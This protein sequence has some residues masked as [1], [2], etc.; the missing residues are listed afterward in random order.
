[1]ETLEKIAYHGLIHPPYP[2]INTFVKPAS[3]GTKL[4]KLFYALIGAGIVFGI[5]FAIGSANDIAWLRYTGMGLGGIIFIFAAI[6]AFKAQEAPCPYCGNALG[7]TSGVL[8]NPDDENL[9]VECPHCFEWSISH[10]GEIRPFKEEDV[11]EKKEF[12]SPLFESG[13]WPNECIVCGNAV[14]KYA[15][16]RNTKLNMGKLLVGRISVAWGSI[17][18]VPYCMEH[19]DKVKLKIDDP[20][21]LLV[22]QDYS[23]RRRYLAV[24]PQRKPSKIKK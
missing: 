4:T 7:K 23:A 20:D 8:L 2:G 12:T 6:Q 9:Q 15:E 1:M 11:K 22:F 14:T 5:L 16:A 24:N 3:F 18:N 19:D 13:A 10:Q 17:K 21:M